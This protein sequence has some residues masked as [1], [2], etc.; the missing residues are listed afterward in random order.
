[1]GSDRLSLGPFFTVTHALVL[2]L[3]VYVL[4]PATVNPTEQLSST[5]KPHPLC[6]FAV[7]IPCNTHDQLASYFALISLLERLALSQKWVCTIRD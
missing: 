1:M 4:L 7:R 5:V 2:A 3:T 6:P